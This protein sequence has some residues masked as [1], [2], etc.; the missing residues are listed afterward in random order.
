MKPKF[1]IEPED[2][3]ILVDPEAYDASEQEFAVSLEQSAAKPKFVVE[4]EPLAERPAL[5]VDPFGVPVAV[6]ETSGM[7]AATSTELDQPLLLA[8]DVGEGKNVEWRQEVA[9]KLSH[10]RS[11]RVAKEPKFPSLRLKFEGTRSDSEPTRHVVPDP[12]PQAVLVQQMIPV[13]ESPLVPTPTT[14]AKVEPTR[15]RLSEILDNSA[16]ILEFPRSNMTPLRRGD[17]LADPILDRPRILE[18]QDVTP[19]AP[20]LGGILIG[21]TERT[22]EKRS[23]FEVPLQAATISRRTV[24]TLVDAAIIGCAVGL[25]AHI[26]RGMTQSREPASQ[27]VVAAAILFGAFWAGYHFLLLPCCGT[28]VGLWLTQLQLRRFDGKPVTRRIRGWRA[29]AAVLSALSVGLGYVWCLLDEDQ[30]CWHDRITRTYV[31]P[32]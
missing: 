27:F 7:A 6:A 12:I 29:V 20:A 15:P 22:E 25:F 24:A 17:E 28:T 18:V 13:E 32:R 21:P 8:A 23:E 3:A 5:A 4:P 2:S 31:S 11:R 16:R 9:A 10:Y 26:F 30:L 14:V 19:P 1:E